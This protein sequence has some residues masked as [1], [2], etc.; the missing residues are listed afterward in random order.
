MDASWLIAAGTLIGLGAY[1]YSVV[2][3]DSPD[4]SGESGTELQNSDKPSFSSISKT[5][6]ERYFGWKEWINTFGTSCGWT[7][8]EQYCP[9]SIVADAGCP[10][11]CTRVFYQ[12]NEA[13]KAQVFNPNKRQW[14]SWSEE[15]PNYEIQGMEGFCIWPYPNESIQISGCDPIRVKA[16]YPETITDG[17]FDVEIALQLIGLKDVFTSCDPDSP[18]YMWTSEESIGRSRA[19]KIDKVELKGGD[20]GGRLLARVMMDNS[21]A[22]EDSE[23][24]VDNVSSWSPRQEI[25]YG[26]EDLDF[27]CWVGLI[28]DAGGDGFKNKS[29]TYDKSYTQQKFTVNVDNS[30]GYYNGTYDL[31]IQINM[32]R[33]V[34]G[35]LFGV[36]SLPEWA[37]GCEFDETVTFTIPNYVMVYSPELCEGCTDGK[38]VMDYMCGSDDINSDG[39]LP[40][41]PDCNSRAKYNYTELQGGAGGNLTSVSAYSEAPN[42]AKCMNHGGLSCSSDSASESISQKNAETLFPRNGFMVW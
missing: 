3:P 17:N 41:S 1:A 20:T 13:M 18:I 32:G 31:E 35:E 29:G 4:E 36:V 5:N 34:D 38:V 11:D 19:I 25:I 22:D 9:S 26:S 16:K 40:D 39:S 2:N 42:S 15:C 23:Y 10:A 12:L 21:A 8:D 7:D 14:S 30:D 24:I 37:E 33:E 27:R 6:P 28:D